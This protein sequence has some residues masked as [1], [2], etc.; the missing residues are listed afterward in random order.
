MTSM[1]IECRTGQGEMS[2]V[3]IFACTLAAVTVVSTVLARLFADPSNALAMWLIGLFIGLVFGQLTLINVW[4]MFSDF[5]WFATIPGVVCAVLCSWIALAFGLSESEML[6]FVTISCAINLL[7]LTTL[8]LV[9]ARL[10]PGGALPTNR[11]GIPSYSILR[12]FGITS[13][14]AVCIAV[15]QMALS[16]GWLPVDIVGRLSVINGVSAFAAVCF[17]FFRSVIA[18]AISFFIAVVAPIAAIYTFEARLIG[19]Y[20]MLVV[21]QLAVIGIGL[22]MIPPQLR[23]VWREKK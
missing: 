22:L 20:S 19:L 18:R 5:R 6:P 8:K 11:A 14:V 7:L 15:T 16:M 17:C 13:F 1:E 4:A 9:G 12:L 23:C 21:M 10:V 3:A 2:R